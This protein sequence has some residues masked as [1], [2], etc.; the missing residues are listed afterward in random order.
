MLKEKFHCPEEISCL[1]ELRGNFELLCTSLLKD[2]KDV[3]WPT[4]YKEIRR[5]GLK[6]EPVFEFDGE[7]HVM[8]LIVVTG[9][10]NVHRVVTVNQTKRGA[11]WCQDG[12][13]V[14]NLASVC[15]KHYQMDEDQIFE[16][17]S[18]FYLSQL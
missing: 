12:I 16:F 6:D 10:V 18:W 1:K 11:I 2:T 5:R 9:E 17:S 3:A 8:W 7:C 14:K 13:L 4:F 15:L